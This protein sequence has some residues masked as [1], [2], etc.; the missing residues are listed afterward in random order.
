M[1]YVKSN[2][3]LCLLICSSI[4]ISGKGGIG[5]VKE[6]ANVGREESGV[7]SISF[8]WQLFLSEPWSCK[9]RCPLQCLKLVLDPINKPPTIVG[10]LFMG[11]NTN[12]KHWS[13]HLILQDQGSL[14]NNCHPKLILLTPLSSLPTF[15]ISL[16]N[17]IPP[18]PLMKML[19]QISKHK[20]LLLF[21]YF[22]SFLKR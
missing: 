10:G 21:T 11:S 3:D 5:F 20:S 13:G 19:E 14:K 1:K 16:T 8:G 12:F 17:P 22:T 18:L 7:K 4:F 9:I 15:A 6:M 2:N